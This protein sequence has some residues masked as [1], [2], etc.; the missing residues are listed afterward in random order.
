MVRIPP[1]RGA[2]ARME[3]RLGDATANPYLAMAAVGAAVCLGIQDKAEPPP[4]L[5][6]YGYDPARAEILPARLGDALD[7]LEADTELTDILGEYFVTSFLAYKRNEI[8][9]FER[10]VTDWEFREYA[11]HL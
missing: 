9:R 5:E 10:F 8:E 2:A 6:G 1:E 7:A 4:K 3:V 11:Y